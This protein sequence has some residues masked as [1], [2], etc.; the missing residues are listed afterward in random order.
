MQEESVEFGGQKRKVRRDTGGTQEARNPEEMKQVSKSYVGAWLSSRNGLFHLPFPWTSNPNS[1]HLRIGS[2]LKTENEETPLMHL[3]T[4]N[5]IS[6]VEKYVPCGICLQDEEFP[7]DCFSL[8]W[9]NT[10][11]VDKGLGNT[12]WLTRLSITKCQVFLMHGVQGKGSIGEIIC[13]PS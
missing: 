4:M 5:T 10:A 13:L 3:K 2:S 1:C 8:R 7:I 11:Y 12:K 9:L 6:Q